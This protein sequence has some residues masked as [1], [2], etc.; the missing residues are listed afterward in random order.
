[1]IEN[2]EFFDSENGLIG[3]IRAI[4]AIGAIEAIGVIIRFI[5]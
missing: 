2:L 5:G 4:R 3:L 1:M